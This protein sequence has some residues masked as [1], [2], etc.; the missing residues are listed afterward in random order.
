MKYFCNIL[1]QTWGFN[2]Q[3]YSFMISNLP[4]MLLLFYNSRCL[5]MF[6]WSVQLKTF[7]TT[8][9]YFRQLYTAYGSHIL[10]YTTIYYLQRLYTSYGCDILLSTAIYYFRQLY[11]TFSFSWLWFCKNTRLSCN[12]RHLWIKSYNN[13]QNIW[14]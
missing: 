4:Y 2:Q 6:V 1:L 7:L 14:D 9:N 3:Y 5:S 8:L 11:T 12:F 10:L 13:S